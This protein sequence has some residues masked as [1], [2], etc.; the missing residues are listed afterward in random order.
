MFI[1]SF[2]CCA[3]RPLLFVYNVNVHSFTLTISFQFFC[4][5]PFSLQ[6]FSFI[7]FYS[8]ASGSTTYQALFCNFTFFFLFIEAMHRVTFY[9]FFFSVTMENILLYFI[10]FTFFPSFSGNNFV[11]TIQLPTT[12]THTFIQKLC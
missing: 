6:L 4:F 11:R 1:K 8:F 2:C 10:L 12:R 9:T 3:V 5:L 7:L